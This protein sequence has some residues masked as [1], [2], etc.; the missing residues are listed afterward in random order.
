VKTE[1]TFRNVF[2][3]VRLSV[4][5][6]E[7]VRGDVGGQGVGRHLGWK[8]LGSEHRCKGAVQGNAGQYYD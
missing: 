2:M 3:I 6:V 8:E 1:R 7:D 4:V 5:L